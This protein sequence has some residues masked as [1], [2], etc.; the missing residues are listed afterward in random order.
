MID[1][2]ETTEALPAYLVQVLEEGFGSLMDAV[3]FIP[4]VANE[5][6]DIPANWVSSSIELSSLSLAMHTG[7][8]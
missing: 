2:H 6:L 1:M 7:I 3:H 5:C 4:R 8:L